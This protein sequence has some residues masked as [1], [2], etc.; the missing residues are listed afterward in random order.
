MVDAGGVRVWEIRTACPELITSASA[1]VL[2]DPSRSAPRHM[3]KKKQ[4]VHLMWWYCS[5]RSQPLHACRMAP[6]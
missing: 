1:S 6:C 2:M 3:H 5:A 4:S